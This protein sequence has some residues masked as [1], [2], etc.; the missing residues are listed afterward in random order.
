MTYKLFRRDF[1]IWK[2]E[3]NVLPTI[4]VVI[5]NAVYCENNFSIEFHFLTLHARLLFLEGV[6]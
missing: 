6:L 5:N 2:N 4:K 1:Q 3:I